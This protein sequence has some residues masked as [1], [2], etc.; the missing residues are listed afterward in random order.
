M[1]VGRYLRGEDRHVG[2][3]RVTKPKVA[4]MNERI[5][6]LIE[7]SR[8]WIQ[9]QQKLGG[10]MYI[11]GPMVRGDINLQRFTEQSVREC[12]KNAVLFAD[13]AKIQGLPNKYIENYMLKHFGVK[14]EIFKKTIP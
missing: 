13:A 10:G 4:E 6:D 1:N 2:T 8:D 14:N 9:S 7:E 3:A 11:P 12:A 5:L